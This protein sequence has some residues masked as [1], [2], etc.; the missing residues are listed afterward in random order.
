MM[1][2]N[3]KGVFLCSKAVVPVMKKQNSGRIIN[4]SSAAVYLGRTDYIHYV[5]SKAG[6]LGFSG[7][8]ARE[9][10]EY[11][12][13]VNSITPGPTYTEIP[14]ETVN[15]DQKQ[16]ML[17]MQSLKRLQVPDDLAGTVVFLSS[18]DSSFITGQV[19]NI[20]GGMNIRI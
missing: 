9:V 19:F 17:N 7:S 11:N 12:I 10:G 5:A 16:R 3:L 20:D 18:D 1:N 14:R 15:D 8:L 4:I 2:V 6:V 13:T